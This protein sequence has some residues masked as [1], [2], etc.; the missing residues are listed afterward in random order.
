MDRKKG[1]ITDFALLQAAAREAVTLGSRITHIIV[2][3]LFRKFFSRHLKKVRYGC[4][5]CPGE[6]GI[7]FHFP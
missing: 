2:R 1:K 5:V 3:G 6:E 7:D 4:I